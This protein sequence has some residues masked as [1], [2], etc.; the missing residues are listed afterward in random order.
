MTDRYMVIHPDTLEAMR[1]AGHVAKLE[2]RIEKLEAALNKF[3][4]NWDDG[5]PMCEPLRKTLEGKDD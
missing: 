3:L 2:A 1:R 4:D 5:G